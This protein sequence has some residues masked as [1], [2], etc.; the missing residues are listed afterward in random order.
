MGDTV[1]KED[2][3]S[4]APWLEG[5]VGNEYIGAAFYE[6]YTMESGL[7]AVAS[8]DTGLLPDFDV[9]AGEGFEPSL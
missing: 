2:R 9:L 8:E 6:G 4:Q 7:E 1:G 3:I 5:P